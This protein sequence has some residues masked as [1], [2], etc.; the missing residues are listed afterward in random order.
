MRLKT[1]VALTDFSAQAEQ[2]LDRAALLA[3]AHQAELRILYGAEVPS[4]KFSDPFAR[5][6]QRGRQIARRHGITT[7]AVS[8]SNDLLPDVLTQAREADLLVIDRRLHRAWPQFWRGPTLEQVIQQAPCPVLVVQQPAT[9]AYQQLLV[10]VDFSQVSRSLVRYASG[11]EVGAAMELFHALDS[12]SQTK[13]R[14]ADAKLSVVHAYERLALN[15]AEGRAVRFTDSLDVRRNRV[16]TL[17]GRGDPVLQVRVQKE[18]SKADLVVVGKARPHVLI[19]WLLGSMAR[20]LVAGL[21]CD[22]LVV[23]HDYHAAGAAAAAP[24]H[25]PRGPRALA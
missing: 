17:T 5:L 3:R 19:D 13:L 7:A 2:C 25:P 20:G 10:A 11:F 21:D 23:P 6:E 22:V 16:G 12:R 24:I 1:I 9:G 18:S 15:N 4:P 14:C 8:G